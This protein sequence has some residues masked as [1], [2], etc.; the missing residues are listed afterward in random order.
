[1][2]KLAY[3]FSRMVLACVALV[4]VAGPTQAVRHLPPPVA[5][6][7]TTSKGV[8][9]AYPWVFQNGHGTSRKTA[10]STA[11]EIARKADYASIPRD[12]AKSAWAS[13]N[14]PKPSFGRLPSAATLKAFGTALH[15]KRVLYGRVS[16]HTRSI[17]VN[18][19]PKTI[20]T[21]TADVYV[22]DVA[23]GK[24][25]FKKTGV[26]GRSDEKSN[27][28]K[29]AADVLVSPLVTAVSGGPATP[30]EQ[31]AAQIAMGVAYHGWVRPSS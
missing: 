15:A 26:Q 20:S 25:V 23:T 29:I 13:H 5:S 27:V 22:F 11:E 1:M 14:F 19:G 24:V 2:K 16:W 18:L 31:R 21:A 6:N 3:S 12:V 4:T 10:F 8:A 7:Q 17:W 30:Q 28:Y 9:V